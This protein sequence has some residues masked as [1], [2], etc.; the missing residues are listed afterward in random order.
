M[1]AISVAAVVVLLSCAQEPTS[2]P[3]S[4]ATE[5]TTSRHAETSGHDEQSV[6]QPL[7]VSND[8]T[9]PVPIYRVEPELPKRLSIAGPILLEAVIDKNG[10]A[11]SVRILRDGTSPPVGPAYVKAIQQWRFRPGTHRGKPVDV[12]Y[13]LSVN[14]HVR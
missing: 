3:K 13:N 10:R 4:D 2:E 11:R 12:L 9:A 14:I 8:V 1:R 5:A 7:R 6:V